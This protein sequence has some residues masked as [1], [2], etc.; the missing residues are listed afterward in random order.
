VTEAFKGEIKVASRIVD[1]LSSG[2]YNSPAA[3]LKELVNN[4]YDADAT[5]VD[6]FVKPDADRII[7]T[8]DGVGMSRDEFVRHFERVSESHKRDDADVTRSGRPKIGKIGIGFIA[9]NELCDV[10]EIISTKEGSTELLRVEVNFAEMRLDPAERRRDGDDF[11]KGDYVGVVEDAP[12]DEHFTHVLL[13]DVT[14]IAKGIL[15]SATPRRHV[16][17]GLSIYGRDPD[18]IRDIVGDAD[19][20]GDLDEYSQT[21]LRVGLNVPV[22]YPPRWYPAG[23]GRTLRRFEREV[24]NLGFGVFVDGSDLRKPVVLGA[25]DRT[26]L[27]PLKI[28]G[29]HVFAHGYMFAKRHVLR[30]QWLNGVLVRIR[31]AAVGEYD[32]TFMGF[33]S[34]EQTL[35]QRWTTCE[36]WADDQLEDA[37]NIDRRTL[38]ITHPAYVELQNAFHDLLSD[39]LREARE[40]LYAEPAEERRRADAHREVERLTEVVERSTTALPADARRELRAAVKERSAST[41]MSSKKDVRAVLRRYSV[42][43]MYD[44]V[45][46]VARETLSEEEYIRFVRA[47]TARLLQ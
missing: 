26:L 6:V 46:E 2:L 32:A 8:D 25:G 18:S 1:Y 13:R 14:E 47:L 37:L 40:T 23:H 28:D 43:D 9:A 29:D 24:A 15:E 30:P 34:T 3:C 44:L 22:L 39:F 10:M 41:R 33:K 38:R 21:M 17:G 27:R 31:H 45:V 7:V 19:N 42:S 35:F 4:S 5:R 16:A 36:V 20:W 12:R 11:V